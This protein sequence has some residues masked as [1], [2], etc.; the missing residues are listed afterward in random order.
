VRRLLILTLLLI[1][2][3]SLYPW[4]FED[5][6]LAHGPVATLLANL[7]TRFGRAELVD[8]V[9]NLLLYFPV[10]LFGLPVFSHRFGSRPALAATL[11]TGFAISAAVEYS[12][13]Y[14]LARDPSAGDVLVNT[15]GTLAGCA[16]AWAVAHHR[17]PAWTEAVLGGADVVILLGAWIVY[18]LFPF[19]PSRTIAVSGHW[20]TGGG[21]AWW[22]TALMHFAGTLALSCLYA[23]FAGR[24]GGV[25]PILPGLVAARLFL[26]GRTLSLV[27]AAAV[28]AGLAAAYA[29]PRLGHVTMVFAAALALHGL[30]PFRL[31]AAPG[32]FEWLPFVSL[33][34]L[35]WAAA[36]PMLSIKVFRYGTLLWLLNLAGWRWRTAGAVT[37]SALAVIEAI[38]RYLPGRT[39]EISDPLLAAI[40]AFVLSSARDAYAGLKRRP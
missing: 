34:D 40:M 29:R 8:I 35:D 9:V 27:E 3:G 6:P 23:A 37:V 39:P 36:F 31:A 20:I 24:L 32:R 13:L 30:A 33:I 38:Q 22:T 28:A 16:I 21:A 19:A 12:Q 10:G 25:F 5:V 11:L 15:A 17:A 2:Y 26:A 7:P 4:R 14:V 1:G 18:Q